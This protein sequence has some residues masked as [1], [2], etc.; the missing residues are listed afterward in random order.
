V[1]TNVNGGGAEAGAAVKPVIVAK[2]V[3]FDTLLIRRLMRHRL[4]RHRQRLVG[5]EI[6][7]Q[8]TVVLKQF[9][10]EVEMLLERKFRVGLTEEGKRSQLFD[11]MGRRALGDGRA[12]DG[13]DGEVGVRSGLSCRFVTVIMQICAVA[14]RGSV[15][16]RGD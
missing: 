6:G 12:R 13:K 1:R 4:C 3:D 15:T 2:L 7:S 9:G 8:A 14:G 10:R 11:L 16:V 5:V